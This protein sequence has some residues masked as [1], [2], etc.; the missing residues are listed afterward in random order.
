MKYILLCGGI[1]SRYNNYSLPKPLNYVQGRHMIE[2]IIDNIPANEIF[3]VYNIFLDQYNFK[4]IVANK[5]KNKK[6]HFSTIEYLTRGAVE[7]AYIGIKP[8]ISNLG[9]DN[10]V[11][12][13]N[14]NLHNLDSINTHYDSHF[15]G[16]SVDETDKTNYSFIE[17]HDG[18]IINIEEKKK[19]SNFFCCGLYG[20]KNAQSFIDCASVSLDN[21]NKTNNEFYFSQLYKSLLKDQTIIPVFIENTK[22]IGSYS[23]IAN[24]DFSVPHKKLRICF[25][26]DNTL[27]TNP[28]VP[29]DYSTVKSIKK[30]IDMLHKFKN[31]GHEIIIYSARRMAT[32]NNNIGKV[33]K[34]IAL[35]T[36]NT[37]DELNIPY[38]ELIFGKP[39]ADIYIDDKSLNPYVNSISYFGFFETVEDFLPNRIDTNKYNSIRFENN[40]IIKTGPYQFMRGEL[41]YYKN[42]PTELST[43]FPKLLEEQQSGDKISMSLEYVKGIPLF[44]LYKHERLTNKIIDDLFAIL[45]RLHSYCPNTENNISEINVKNNYIEKI[46]SRFSNKT[47]YPFD[48]AENVYDEIVS[49]LINNY[50]AK[51]VSTIHGDFWFSNILMTYDDNYK[52]IDMKGQVDGI[53]TLNGDIYYDYGKLYQSIIGY[54]LLLNGSSLNEIYVSKMKSYFLKKCL[55]LGM[56]IDY[57]TFVTKSLIFGTFH[58]IDKPI[59]IKQKIWSLLKQRGN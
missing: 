54:D 14:D 43:L 3:I 10:I 47:D 51:I 35:T 59:E 26:L 29:D 55:D 4:E 6:I 21:N 40:R 17:T 42:I 19:I 16:Y 31:D 2:I 7:T 53:L 32:H 41:Y 18:K 56:N 48:D 13:D 30:N 20:F 22:H 15:I 50:S 5:F 57:L 38:D 34:D 44:Y 49:G 45:N 36:I 27:V 24:K 39:I 46:K 23:E 37:L 28:T 58:F 12:I 11:F 9:N 33:I 8:F 25:D 1:G 52:L